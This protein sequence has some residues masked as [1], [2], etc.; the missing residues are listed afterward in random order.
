MWPVVSRA[1]T[2]RRLVLISSALLALGALGGNIWIRWR[3]RPYIVA[4][5][6][7]EPAQVAIV[8]GA[9][10]YNDHGALSS[11]LQDRVE[12]AIELY[13]SGRVKALLMSGDH[14]EDGYDEVNSMKA[15]AEKRGVPS[16]VIFLDHAGFSTYETMARAIRVFQVE[17][18]VIV[19]NAFH[20]ERSVFVAR[21]LG[22]QA[23]GTPAR[24]RPYVDALHNEMRE[25]AARCKALV[26]VYLWAPK[27]LGGP[28]IPIT[29]PAHLSHDK[30][31]R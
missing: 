23:Q 29:G 26:S 17:R 5:D 22:L 27:V 14:G 31:A 30:T 13:R 3:A 10:V 8:P 4:P 11:V 25:F 19:T 16:E 20:L 18:A 1:A 9:M 21:A 15:Y 6:Q 28:L 12:R 7:L 24:D 2:V